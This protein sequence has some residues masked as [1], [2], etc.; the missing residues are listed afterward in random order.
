MINEITYS[1]TINDI[2][3]KHIDLHKNE[4]KKKIFSFNYNCDVVADDT[5]NAI[6]FSLSNSEQDE[7]IIDISNLSLEGAFIIDEKMSK[8]L[9]IYNFDE[10]NCSNNYF[11]IIIIDTFNINVKKFSFDNNPI[12]E[13]YFPYSYIENIDNLP[14]TLKK[15]YFPPDSYFNKPINDLPSS[16]EILSTGQS[17]N[18][19]IDNLPKKLLHLSLGKKFNTQINK[20]PEELQTLI[21]ED[22]NKY[23]FKLNCLPDSIKFISLPLDFNTNENK[24]I[25]KNSLEK[26]IFN[27]SDHRQFSQLEHNLVKSLSN[28]YEYVIIPKTI[29][30]YYSYNCSKIKQ[31]IYYK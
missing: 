3:Y 11:N 13:I 10:I 29:D 24:L 14:N 16:L 7:K 21:F 19:T 17:F 27:I 2:D 26:I 31:K 15:I 18:Q 30:D 9:K 8:I 23:N 25:L 20:L 28:A 4:Y 6:K 12:E 22:G 1:Q 5:F